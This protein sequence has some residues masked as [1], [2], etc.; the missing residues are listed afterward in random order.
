MAEIDRASLCVGHAAVVENLQQNVRDIGVRLFEFVEENHAIRAAPHRFGELARFVVPGV[1]RRRAE[2]ARDRVRFGE[3]RE[4][5]AHERVV[6]AEERFGERFGKFGFS[7]AARTAEEKAAER[8]A[9]IVK[10]GARAANRFGD[11]V[12]IAPALSDHARP[13]LRFEFEQR[14]SLAIRRGSAAE[15]RSIFVTTAATCSARYR[16]HGDG[17]LVHQRPRSPRPRPSESIALSG[18]NRSAM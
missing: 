1:S 12:A 6:G 9:R 17:A 5:D 15:C 14:V 11:T 4:I 13:E 10:S 18:K 16:R 7:D 3:F 8:L 2:Q